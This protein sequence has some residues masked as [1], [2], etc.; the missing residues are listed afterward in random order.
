[1]SDLIDEAVLQDLF[2]RIADEIPVP[3]RGAGYAVDGLA[4]TTST[5][6]SDRVRVTASVLAVAAVLAGVVLA[7]SSLSTSTSKSSA[8]AVSAPTRTASP[9]V[10]CPRATCSLLARRFSCRAGR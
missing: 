6:R 9:C 4:N 2:G 1:M 10:T 7:L 8:R 3:P 5:G